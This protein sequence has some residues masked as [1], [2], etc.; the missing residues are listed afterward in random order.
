MSR[1]RLHRLGDLDREL[2][3]RREHEQLRLRALQVEPTQERQ[4]E[5][6]GLAGA[7]LGLP[8]H[9]PAFQKRR[10]RRPL[11]GRRR[12]VADVANRGEYGFREPEIVE[13]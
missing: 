2:P 4:S 11:D 5:R 12:L 1:V 6:R 13:A 9:V 10:N 7:G 3:R 8:E